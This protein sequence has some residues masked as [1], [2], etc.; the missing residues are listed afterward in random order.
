MKRS[1][2][3]ALVLVF[4]FSFAMAHLALAKDKDPQTRTV[5]GQVTDNNGQALPNAIVYLKN[6]KTLAVKTFIAQSDGSYRFHAL[7]P[8][9]DY[10][11]HAEFNGQRSDNKTIS[12]F[13]SRSNLTVH[14][15]VPVARK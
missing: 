13:D 5:E 12:Q 2:H 8:N 6:A 7:S 1:V 3:G 9:V 15:K 11:L 10:E 4:A 14:L